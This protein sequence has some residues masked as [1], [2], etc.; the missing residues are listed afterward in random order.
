MVFFLCSTT[1]AQTSE[2]SGKVVNSENEVI[3]FANILLLSSIDSTFVQGTS[4]GEDGFFKLEEVVPDLYLLQAS[5][6]GR[7]SKPLALDIQQS[8]KL[9]ALIIPTVTENLD[10]VVVTARRPTV[11]RLADRLVF[12]VENSIVSQGSSWDIL[13]GTPGVIVNQEDL[14][15]RGQNANVYINDRKVQLSGQEVRDLL[16]GLSGVNIKSVEV[17]PNPPA[18]YEAESGPIL[19]IVTSKNIVPGYKGSVNSSYTQAIYPKYSIGTSQYF[20]TEKLNLFANYTY[21]PRKDNLREQKGINFFDDN[22]SV[23]SIWSSEEEGVSRSDAHNINTSLDYDFDDNNTINITSNI[24]LNNNQERNRDIFTTIKNSANQIDSTFTTGNTYEDDNTNL[25]FDF[26]YIHKLNKPGASLSLNGHYT[27]FEEESQQN[28]R[29]DYVDSGGGFLRSFGFRTDALQNIDI[30]TGQLDYASPLGNA[31]IESGIKYSKVDSQ[32][33]ID[34]SNFIG[35]D[36]SVNE[37]LSDDFLYNEEIYAAYLSF[38]KSWEK[39][40]MKLGVRGEYTNA[41]GISLTLG[42]TNNQDFFEPFPSVYFLY[43]ASDKHSFAFDYGRK[44]ARPRYNDLNPFRYFT[45]END[46]FEGNPGLVPNFSN[47]F[48]INYTLNSEYFFDFYY[49]DNGNFISRNL[50]FQDNENQVLRESRQN[51]LASTS[52]GLDFTV[53]KSI[54]NPWFLYAYMS[55]FHEDE[56]FLAVESGNQEFTNEVNGYFVYLANYFTLSEDGTLGGEVTFSHMSNILYG[57]Y[58]QDPYT[59]LTIGLRKSLWN[60]RAV[61]S[62]SAEDLLGDVNSVLRSRYL[63]QDNTYFGQ[64]ETQFI[65]VGF[66]YNF[67]NFRLEDNQRGIDKKERDRLSKED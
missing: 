34:F 27:R 56:T 8:V 60:N 7:G 35:N 63:N 28:I 3:P 67:G 40:S 19:N 17:I 38:V 36:D 32:S 16:E 43:S 41:E 61:V 57:S 5:Y 54:A 39:F 52:Y 10:E 44:V 23:N 25:A 13:K 48:N 59:D 1:S 45:N 9:G 64:P 11:Q 50:I 46:F 15:I 18:R 49:R 26:S 37:G 6:I 24:I 29:S 33:T 4:A 55:V 2:I 12:Q 31:S 21:N 62:I 30:F 65:R 20:K 66:T 14:Q 58:K 22:N 42:Q 47:N 53:S 51:V